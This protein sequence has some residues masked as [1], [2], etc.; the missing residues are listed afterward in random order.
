MPDW[1]SGNAHVQKNA[2][3]RD[4]P[5]FNGHTFLTDFIYGK[6]LKSLK[7]IINQSDSFLKNSC[8]MLNWVYMFRCLFPHQRID[9]IFTKASIFFQKLRN[10]LEHSFGRMF[11]VGGQL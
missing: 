2:K 11:M 1:I 9:V 6:F 3:K 10:S 7:S 5:N 8:Q 4:K